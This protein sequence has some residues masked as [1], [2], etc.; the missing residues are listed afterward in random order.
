VTYYN[1]VKKNISKKNKELFFHVV[2]LT[3]EFTNLPAVQ[4]EKAQSAQRNPFKKLF[5]NFFLNLCELRG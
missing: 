1:K 4:A 3:T 5:V 2:H